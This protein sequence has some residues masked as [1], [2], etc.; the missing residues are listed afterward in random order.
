M[1]IE[2]LKKFAGWIK[3]CREVKEY[4]ISSIS[5][6]KIDLKFLQATADANFDILPE[7]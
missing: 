2:A 5:K 4:L 3:N 6:T 7:I 1:A